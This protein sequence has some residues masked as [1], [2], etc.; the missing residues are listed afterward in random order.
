[1]FNIFAAPANGKYLKRYLDEV[2]LPGLPGILPG[3]KLMTEQNSTLFT[4]LQ[5]TLFCQKVYKKCNSMIR[6]I[7]NFTTVMIIN[8]LFII[9]VD[10]PVS[11]Y[12]MQDVK[13]L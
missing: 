11:C 7:K 5:I 6:K 13:M 12:L 3:V 10:D 1:M 8:A 4:G 9:F 2:N